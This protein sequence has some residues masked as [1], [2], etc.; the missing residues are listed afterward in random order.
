MRTGWR[1]K[2]ILLLSEMT[3]AGGRF[4]FCGG[5]GFCRGQVRETGVC[6]EGDARAPGN[7]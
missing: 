4:A 7:A 6:T 1:G 5:R 3:G 2:P